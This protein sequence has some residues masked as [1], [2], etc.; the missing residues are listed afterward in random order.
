VP[1]R[2]RT[3]LIVAFVAGTTLNIWTAF[4]GVARL[5]HTFMLDNATVGNVFEPPPLPAPTPANAL[6]AL[7]EKRRRELQGNFGPSAEEFRYDNW[8]TASAAYNS[9]RLDLWE[10][11]AKI[12]FGLVAL[13]AIIW[14]F[15]RP[16]KSAKAS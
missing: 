16:A 12:E 7:I 2:L 14:V 9:R 5:D 10:R 11:A 1:Q 8:L 15:A 13:A 6:D 4:D 3:A